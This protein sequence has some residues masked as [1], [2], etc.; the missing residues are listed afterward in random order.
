MGVGGDAD[1]HPLLPGHLAVEVG[2]VKALGVGV[3]LQVAAPVAGLA[4]DAGHVDVVGLALGDQPPGGVGEDGEVGVVH[5]LEDAPGLVGAAEVELAVH[6][7]DHQVELAQ[8]L[9]RQVQAAVR[10][11]VHLDALEDPEG[12]PF[13]GRALAGQALVQA[14]DGRHLLQEPP[15]V[16]PMGHGQALGVV[17]DG[18]VV[19]PPLAGGGHHLQQAGMAVG[20]VGMAVQVAAQVG[21]GHQLWQQAPARGLDL[22]AVLP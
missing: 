12:H 18:Q 8:D 11:D 16:Q 20:G 7:G 10:E 2:E 22:P 14:V 21:Q 6:P 15:A 19:A 5:G 3:E 9:I 4:D 1:Q 13:A 17:G